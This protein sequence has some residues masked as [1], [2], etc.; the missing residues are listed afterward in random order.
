MMFRV[1][2]IIDALASAIVLIFFFVGLVD[3]SVSSFNMD[4]WIGIL[5]LLAVVLVGSLKLKAM[6]HPALSKLL[7]LIIAIP[8]GIYLLFLLLFISSG[9]KWI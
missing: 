2:W 8:A 3:G 4:I 7:L 1:L 5:A 6:G 9:E